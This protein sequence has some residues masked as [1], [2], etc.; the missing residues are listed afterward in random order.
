MR[1]RSQHKNPKKIQ[2][3]TTEGKIS[4]SSKGDG[5]V[6]S[7]E[8]SED[9][10]VAAENTGT[11][12]PGDTVD[13]SILKEDRGRIS[14]KVIKVIERAKKNFVGTITKE[15]GRTIFIPDN[16][17]ILTPFAIEKGDAP[18]N[19]KVLVELIDWSDKRDLP[20]AVIKQ[21]IGPKGENETEMKA[22]AL[23]RGF[24]TSFPE[25]V[26]R[27]AEMIKERSR[28]EFENEIKKR[29]DFRNT[30]T[31]TIDPKNAKDFDDAISFKEI[32]GG[33]EIGVHIADVSHYVRP[34]TLLEKEAQKRGTSIYLVD[35]T[36][37][38]L[39]EVLSNDLCSL[40]PNEEKLTFGAIFEMTK[41]GAVKK[42]WF[43]K[44]LIRSA[45]RFTYEEAQAAIDGKL[46]DHAKELQTLN[47]LAKML[48]EKRFEKGAISFEQDEVYFELDPNG[49]PL[50]VHRKERLD[51]HKLI[52]E[53]M[54]LAN[55][56]VATFVTRSVKNKKDLAPLFVYRIH[57][58]PDPEK[59]AQ[60]GLFL[61]AIGH[62]IR[63]ENGRMSGKDINALFKKIEGKAEEGVIKTAAIRSMAKAIYST[64]NIGHFGLGFE[65]Y[66][67]FT[68]PIRR[69]PDVMVH[70]LLEHYLT[71][72]K[73]SAEEFNN[74]ERLAIAATEAEIRAAEAERESI[75]LKQ[76]EFMQDKV[77]QTLEGI[78]SGVTE[79]GM[80][81][82]E[83]ETKAEGLVK[84]RDLPDDY[85]NLDAKNYRLVGERTKKIYSLGDPVRF[86]IV[87]ADLER[88]TLD[89][90]L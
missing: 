35:R 19:N 39:P 78:I 12:L 73:I 55:R 87:G 61:K 40:N 63:M 77:G 88:K 52:E 90:I 75:K 29:R 38:M 17:K 43:G 60:L 51:T 46:K 22:I 80:Y 14:G 34:G 44:T 24:Q 4:F 15:K 37:P 25:D 68:S 72:G 23:E 82:E 69:Y 67:H 33:Y 11:S 26:E 47:R 48:Y 62:E 79:W 36:I 27:E 76:V 86:K 54:L 49:K 5:Y 20:K 28:G 45:R 56:E 30:L 10:Y 3:K 83:K 13:I 42:S 89:L 6:T 1:E 66:T 85:Y 32:D 9:V 65:Y 57:D 50:S 64:K 41:D 70:R 8:F 84:L 71:G 58:L 74:F 53:F 18:L 81:I 7:P 59:M 16:R 31:F 21:V 2:S